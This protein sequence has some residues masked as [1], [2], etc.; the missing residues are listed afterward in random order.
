MGDI[1]SMNAQSDDELLEELGRELWKQRSHATPPSPKSLQSEA[2]AWLR[3][4]LP[5]AKDGVCG[6]SIVS[7]LRNNS[8]EVSLIAAIAD[9][10]ANTLG[11]PAPSAVAILV[12]RIGLDKLCAGW[13]PAEQ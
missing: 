11:F 3:Q 8:D 12:F 1:K 6:N 4:N 5:K 7:A 9:I 2:K 10:F 13:K